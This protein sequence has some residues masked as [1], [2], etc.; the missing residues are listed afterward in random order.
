VCLDPRH[1][2]VLSPL[3]LARSAAL[4]AT[5]GGKTLG[6]GVRYP[7]LDETEPS[8]PHALPMTLH[9][10]AN[11]RDLSDGGGPLHDM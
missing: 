10:L 9:A 1:D 11:G 8:L 3:V 2:L 4:S 5:F 6:A 7:Q